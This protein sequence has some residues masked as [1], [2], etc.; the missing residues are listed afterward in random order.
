MEKIACDDNT[1]HSEMAENESFDQTGKTEPEKLLLRGY[2]PLLNINTPIDDQLST[3]EINRNLTDARRK[4]YEKTTARRGR[5]TALDE[6]KKGREERLAAS[7]ETK[8]RECNDPI[9]MFFKSMAL[10]V[11]TFP[12]ELAVEA[13]MR[14]FNIVSEMEL[15]SLKVKANM[16]TPPVEPMTSTPSSNLPTI[17]GE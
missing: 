11:S 1:N 12:P 8:L 10:T 7:R 13:K 6:I 17:F 14:V 4:P 9:Q 15:R 16:T 5:D 2:E 3:K